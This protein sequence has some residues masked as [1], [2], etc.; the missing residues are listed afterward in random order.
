MSFYKL[1]GGN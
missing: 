1:V